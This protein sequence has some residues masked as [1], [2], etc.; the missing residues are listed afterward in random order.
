MCTGTLSRYKQSKWPRGCRQLSGIPGNVASILF[1]SE[2]VKYLEF[3]HGNFAR[4]NVPPGSNLKIT[5]TAHAPNA[6]LESGH[7]TEFP[8]RE[9]HS[10][11]E[12]QQLLPGY[13]GY[14]F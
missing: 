4:S 7:S 6:A 5:S 14:Q 9:G 11:T 2:L 10:A 3:R 13:L 1:R 12:R 8:G